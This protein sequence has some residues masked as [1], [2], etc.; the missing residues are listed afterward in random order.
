MEKINKLK[1]L[2]FNNRQTGHTSKL[3]EFLKSNDDFILLVNNESEAVNVKKEFNIIN[4]KSINN[5][6]EGLI[7]SGKSFVFDNSVIL[8]MFEEFHQ[9]QINAENSKAST[10]L[11]IEKFFK[12]DGLHDLGFLT[13]NNRL[14]HQFNNVC[15][16]HERD[17]KY[18]WWDRIFHRK[19]VEKHQ[20]WIK[21]NQKRFESM[22][23]EQE[24]KMEKFIEVMNQNL[25]PDD[26][27]KA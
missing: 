27:A 10:L 3:V 23:I 12:V 13:M 1:D 22:I 8:S 17:K 9:H 5:K 2:I 19:D 14:L 18:T 25:K 21:N 24:K 11:M 20:K 7:T 15:R 4:V 26:D 16:L 6:L